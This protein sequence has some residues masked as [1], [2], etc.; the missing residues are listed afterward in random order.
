MGERGARRCRSGS[1]TVTHWQVYDITRRSSFDTLQAWVKELRQLG[2]ENI[3]ICV[4]GNKSDLKDKRVRVDSAAMLAVAVSKPRGSRLRRHYCRPSPALCPPLQE[5][6]T[7]DAKRYAQEI[8]ALFFETSAKNSDA[9]G[10]VQEMF[11]ELAR[12]L[13][14]AAHE[15]VIGDTADL[16]E[17]KGGKA[18]GKGGKGG[19]V[20]ASKDAAGGGGCC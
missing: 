14:A 18:G 3:I 19:K 2:P 10:R 5:V 17:P 11:V 15:P 20:G 13:P 4:C 8:G 9:S 7:A 6:E 12:M 1:A 16:R